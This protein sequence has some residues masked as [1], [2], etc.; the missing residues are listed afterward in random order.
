MEK[1]LFYVV[2]IIT[3]GS[4][5]SVILQRKAMY[6]VLSLVLTLLGVAWIYAWLSAPFLAIV[7]V[8]LYAGAI[9]VL[10]LFVVMTLRFEEVE[11]RRL[12]AGLLGCLGLLVALVFSGE[13]ITP[14]RV[15]LGEGA[16]LP[17]DFG[18]IRSLGSVLYTQYLLPVELAGVLLLVAVVGAVVLA[19]RS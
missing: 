14:L 1:I 10:F 9:V 13:L 5:A 6:S 16:Q 12:G 11:P 15:S 19:K 8:I 18:G 7:Q 17:S 3:L 2:A 4:G